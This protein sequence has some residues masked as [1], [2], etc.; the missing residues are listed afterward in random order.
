MYRQPALLLWPGVSLFSS[1]SPFLYGRLCQDYQNH[2]GF[3]L[4]LLSRGF[5]SEI[6]Q[7]LHNT[8]GS[9]SEPIWTRASERLP[10]AGKG[11][12]Q[13]FQASGGEGPHAGGLV[14]E[15][16]N[17][18]T[19]PRTPTEHRTLIADRLTQARL[20]FAWRPPAPPSG[21]EP[22]GCGPRGPSFGCTA[23]DATPGPHATFRGHSQVT[24][25]G[26]TK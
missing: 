9:E 19:K 18:K 26:D 21:W 14:A 10:F 13:Q 12:T 17:E 15:P 2:R 6:T 8:L 5:T 4:T 16:A 23:L 25:S 3:T 22:R 11:G 7:S 24:F 20:E 1:L